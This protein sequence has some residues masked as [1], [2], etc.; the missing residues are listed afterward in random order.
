MKPQSLWKFDEEKK[1]AIEA[2]ILAL[3]QSIDG[4][5]VQLVPEV[6]NALTAAGQSGANQGAEQMGT[7][8]AA[9]NQQAAEYARDRAAEL[10]GRK[11]N[12]A[13]ELVDNPDAEWVIAETTRARIREIVESAFAENATYPEIT[14]AI[15]EALEAER[16]NGGI[17]SK[18]RAAMIARNEVVMAQAVANYAAWEASGTVSKLR[19]TTAEDEIVCDECGPL[20]GEETEIGKPFSDG[21]LHPPAHINCRC[22]AVVSEVK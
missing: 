6:T 14:K 12:E 4:S 5:W 11:Y 1:E 18:E 7:S 22:V 21:S 3:M 9:G 2:Y 17:F 15:L 20:D 8:P 10:V 13:G 19:W 16:E